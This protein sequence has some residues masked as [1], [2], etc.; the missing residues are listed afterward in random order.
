MNHQELR[1]NLRKLRA[2]LQQ[3]ESLDGR[4]REMFQRLSADIEELL[5]REDEQPQHWSTLRER[6]SESLAQL[7]ASHPQ[8]TLLMRQAVDSLAYLGV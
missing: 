1:T 3:T 8:V 5:A 6:L 4:E 7:E 2:E